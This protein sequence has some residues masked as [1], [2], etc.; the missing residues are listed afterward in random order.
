MPTVLLRDESYAHIKENSSQWA[1]KLGLELSFPQ[2]EE[3][4]FMLTQ[5]QAYQAG[6]GT[7]YTCKAGI[8][9]KILAPECP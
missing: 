6:L 8:E 9:H 1:E 3:Q 4:V 2:D 7:S 5:R